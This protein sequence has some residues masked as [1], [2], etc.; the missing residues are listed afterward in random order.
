MS[1]GWVF[2]DDSE[3][4]V[5][6]ICWVM[7][8]AIFRNHYQQHKV[9]LEYRIPYILDC[10]PHPFYSFRGLKNYM[11]IR[12]ECGLHSR[13][14]A[15]FWKNDRASVLTVRTIQRNNLV[16]YL[17]FILYNI[18]NLL[19]IILAI[20]THNWIVI[21]HPVTNHLYLHHRPPIECHLRI[22]P[23]HCLCNT[24]WKIWR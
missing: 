9:N 3:D 18:Y 12:I 5:V 17:L 15:G 24:S 20:I 2:G 14:R 16:F 23:K 19:F 4:L 1:I 10:N 7:Q 22:R 21:L 8:D 13:S 6:S 11:R